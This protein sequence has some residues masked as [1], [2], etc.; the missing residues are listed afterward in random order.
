MRG[1]ACIGSRDRQ[2][3][4]RLDAP[5]NK[6]QLEPIERVKKTNGASTLRPIIDDFLFNWEY[7]DESPPSSAR[8]P[9]FIRAA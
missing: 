1:C 5:L 9:Y 3:S 4:S 7:D 8:W 6:T 2:R